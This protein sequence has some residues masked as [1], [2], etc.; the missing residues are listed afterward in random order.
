MFWRIEDNGSFGDW[1][2]YPKRLS[3]NGRLVPD[4]TFEKKITLVT[5]GSTP[6][7][8]DLAHRNIRTVVGP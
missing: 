5:W 7:R 8:G 3:G 6:T 2:S 4:A 1:S